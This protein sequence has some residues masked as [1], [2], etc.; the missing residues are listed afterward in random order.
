MSKRNHSFK[1]RCLEMAFLILLVFPVCTV[2]A[3]QTQVAVR[4]K[5]VSIRDAIRQIEESS[6][7]VFFYKA[8]DLSGLSPKDLDCKGDIGVVLETLFKGSGISYVIKGKEII[9]KPAGKSKEQSPQQEK[10]VT[11]SGII[12]DNLGET[13]IGASVFETGNATNGTITDLDGKFTL[14]V[15]SGATLTV[16][17]IGYTNQAI[18]VK[19]GVTQY[20]VTLKE[21]TQLL[22]EVVVVGYGTQKK[23]NLT[24][25]V[26]SVSTDE[27]KDRVQTNVLSA[28]QGTVPGVTVISR[29][30]QSP[31]INFRG[32]G[33]LGSSEPL[34]VIDGTIADATFFSNLDPNSI[35]SISFL[36]DA[37]SSSIYG[38]R[39]AY[40]VV[41]VTTKGGKQEKMN[42]S[43]S[44][45]VGLQTPTYLPK[46]VSSHEYASM[47]NEAM[48]NRDANNGKFA[49]YSQEQLDLFKSGTDP[50]N[51]PNTDWTDLVLD[52]TVMT[53]QHSLNFSG[54]SEKVR[55]FIGLGYMYGDDFVP[56]K[57]KNR[58]NLNTNISSDITE[59][60]TVKAGIKY[61]RNNN[62]SDNGVPW[63]AN[64]LRCPPTMAARQSWGE[65]G[66]RAGGQQ[67]TQS[68]I[69]DNPLR[70]LSKN[71]WSHSKWENTMYDLGFDIK[72]VKGLVI[73]GQGS[74]KGYEYK[75]KSYTALQDN[76]KDKD[77][78]EISGTGTY[79][80]SMSMTWQSTTQML[81]TGTIRY[82]WD[83]EDHSF[84]A[85]LGTSYEH[86]KFENLSA[87]RKNFPNDE[88]VD[89]G[90]GSSAGQ[91]ISN[92]GGMSEYKLQSYFARLNYSYK[93]RYLFEAN[94]RADA[95]SRFHKD[96]RRGWFPSFS[97]GWRISEEDFMQ[98]VSWIDNLK[99][100][101]SWGMLGNINNVGNYDYLMTY[102]TGYYYTFDDQLVSGI[103]E[104][105]PAN[106]NLG[107]ETVA[108]TNIG[109]D[110]DLFGGKLNVTADYYLKNTSDILLAYNVPW[111]TGI[112]VPPSQ[113]IGKVRNTGFELAVT[114]RN[115]IGNL[116]Y[117]VSAN[118]ATNKNEITNLG[119]SNDLD[120]GGGDNY[121]FILRE[122]EAI[123]SFYGY[124]TD[125][126]YTQ[127][128]IDAGDYYLF[129]RHPQAG[130]IKYIPV[131]NGVKKYNELTEDEILEGASAAT[132]SGDDR[133]IIG[134][135]V[136][137]FTYGLNINLNWKNFELSLFGQGV[138]GTD[139]AFESE[140]V[141]AFMINST[142]R[143]FHRK[144]WTEENPNPRAAYPRI[145][146]GSSMDDYNQ[147][148]SDYQLF[149]SDYFRI[150]TI[151]LGYMVPAETVK[152]W[153]LSSLKFFLT[154]ENLLTFRADKLM[155]DF[156][157]ES[158]SSRGLGALG[159]K[160][161][162][163]GVNVSF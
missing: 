132:I 33:N 92:G 28:V 131:R 114:H 51:Y 101:A 60:L 41:L 30:G 16:S 152:S 153:G 12:K 98:N 117:S 6:E 91:D 95:S 49:L 127:E 7:Y 139:V 124:K 151:S 8:T 36:K 66:S 142:P 107:W 42:V 15:S 18:A 71:D 140:Q 3:A 162:A 89:L 161:V 87:S 80:N 130:D 147:H 149:D 82:D 79:T 55:Y 159:I 52:K 26:A 34:Y 74:F 128:E 1:K 38:S 14:T 160:S 126:L 84:G 96:N 133:T 29:P 47:M 134:K 75:S 111:E 135:D 65:W 78:N 69:Q 110:A 104:S 155:K 93:E 24:G 119:G 105:R 125:G 83:M 59:W 81:Y 58:Y 39:A 54:G 57:S 143:E 21:D 43:Y 61:I 116:S 144:R 137:S 45:Y 72:P 115:K 100:R 109:V 145:Y 106:T 63:L 68:F 97:A 73:S 35:E 19:P 94:V 154:G 46:L 9:L 67:A 76:V 86:Y 99:L 122:G 102:S 2:S 138:S 103:S 88:L 146:G 136:P 40:G 141:F 123:G 90:A 25:S 5:S 53:T 4:G 157:P 156:D 11:V 108:Q 17:Y 158:P 23:V 31:E 13:I 20:N 62:D 70:T 129:G 150:K 56:G 118:I 77:G 32:R 48:Y 120:G 148:F 22:S 44:G 37:A 163:F 10:K 113:N 64:L 121:K 85:L 50:D 112:S 27:I